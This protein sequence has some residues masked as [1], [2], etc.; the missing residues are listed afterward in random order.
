MLSGFNEAAAFQLRN[1]F[2]GMG[3]YDTHAGGFNEAAAFQLRNRGR[4]AVV[5][6][7]IKTLQ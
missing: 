5:I 6:A 7:P 3:G 4:F 1:L 2:V